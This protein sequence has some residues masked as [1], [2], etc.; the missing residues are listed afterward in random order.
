MPAASAHSLGNA[1]LVKAKVLFEFL[2]D[3]VLP[4]LVTTPAA[5]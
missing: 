2:R 5:Q 3:R 4:S 1:N